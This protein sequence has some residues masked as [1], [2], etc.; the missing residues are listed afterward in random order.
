MKGCR[1]VLV[2]DETGCGSGCAALR[3]E[4]MGEGGIKGKCGVPDELPE[5]APSRGVDDEADAVRGVGGGVADG[6]A[7]AAISSEN[8]GG[9]GGC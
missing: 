3:K 6:A 5:G 1:R 8:G 7:E 2:V 4:A 9:G